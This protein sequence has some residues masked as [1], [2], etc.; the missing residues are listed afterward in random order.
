MECLRDSFT[1]GLLLDGRFQ[2]ISPLNHGS[3]GMVFMAKDTKTEDLVAIKCLT[4]A[5]STNVCPSVL[6]IDDRSDELACHARLGYHPN[7]VNLIHSFET[8]AHLYLVLEF[9]TMGD[10]YEAIRLGRGPL[11]T[12][13]VRDFMLQLVDAVTY[14]HSKGLYH[15]DI[16]PENT[17]LAQDG[18][19]KLGD[20]GLA[21]ADTWSYEVSVGSDRYMAPEQYD[22]AGIGYSPAKAD[23][24]AIGICLLNIIFSRNPFVTPIESDL[25]FAD[26]VRDRQSL[27]DVFPNMSQDTFEVL[28]YAM[29]I[30]PEK[31]DLSAVRHAINRVISFTTDDETLDDFCTEDREVVQASANR[32]PLRTPSIQSP[33]VDQGGTFPWAKALHMSPP[34]QVRQLSAIPDVES[35][36]EDLFPASEKGTSSWYSV[37]PQTPSMASVLD[38]SL[39]ASLKPVNIARSKV[40]SPPRSDP[41]S[42]SG[43][44]PAGATKPL[45]AMTM[46]FGNKDTAS[47]SWS[48]LWDEEEEEEAEHERVLQDRREQNSRSWSQES[49]DDDPTI[50]R[51]G[52]AEL[53]NSSFVNSRTKSPEH[54]GINA[55]GTGFDVVDQNDGFFFEDRAPPTT[56][57]YSPPSKRNI[58]DKWAMLGNRR[59]ASQSNNT[60]SSA[61]RFAIGS[62]RRDVGLDSGNDGGV[63]DRKFNGKSSVKDWRRDNHRQQQ[64]HQRDDEADH[65]WVGGWHDLHL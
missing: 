11:E 9:C 34:Q 7:I 19:L 30:D 39:G 53:K 41:V 49:K 16:K 57:R 17:F 21:T 24:W 61:K 13:H 6:T 10:L 14:M 1:E 40:L 4:K 37:G 3:F 43:S 32:E 33:H 36:T 46:I 54:N 65:E 23:I 29:A 51:G 27:F 55:N 18:S 56:P 5:S 22:S 59:R 28:V 12:E 2:T 26:Y 8:G 31:R 25:L 44:L 62:W 15:R 48:D 35:D 52:L 42:T 47:K 58:M 38:S 45:P 63:W 64:H 50:R 20:F 60:S